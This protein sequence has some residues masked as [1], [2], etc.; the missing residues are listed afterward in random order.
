MNLKIGIN[1]C[2]LTCPWN[3][4]R[5]FFSW[6][7]SSIQGVSILSIVTSSLEHVLEN[8]MC[9]HMPEMRDPRIPE[10]I[11]NIKFYYYKKLL[12]TGL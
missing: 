5:F 9:Y 1:A 3:I 7:F 11:W 12:S 2:N 8:E 4:L 10:I 6:L